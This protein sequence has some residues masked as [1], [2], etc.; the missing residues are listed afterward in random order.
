MENKIQNV[1][2]SFCCKEEWN[3]FKTVDERR[4]FCGSCKHNVIDFTKATQKELD[5]VLKSGARVCGRFTASQ[6][7]ETFLRYAASA[8]VVASAISIS[9]EKPVEMNRSKTVE[10]PVPA[11]IPLLPPPE[12]EHYVMGAV[13]MPLDSLNSS[14]DSLET[15]SPIP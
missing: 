6:M 3:T 15:T 9:C 7:S 8:V 11:L 10:S 13:I 5:H 2:L 4:R 1:S 12:E 14:T